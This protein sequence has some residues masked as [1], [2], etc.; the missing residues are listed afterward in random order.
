MN[1]KIFVFVVCGKREHIDTLHLSL[2]YLKKYSKHEIKI[3]TDSSRNEIEILHDQVID[4]KTPTQYSHHQASIY[5]KTGIHNFL[6]KDNLYCYLDTDVVAVSASC[7]D[8]FK[9]FT[10][11]I[12]FAVD[13]CKIRKFSSS[14]VHC[15]CQKNREIDRQK[16]LKFTKDIHGVTVTNPFLIEK[17]KELQFQFDLLKKSF[18]KKL[19]T[20]L[21]FFLSRKQFHLNEEFYFNKKNKTWHIKNGDVVM[22][23]VDVEK[24]QNATGLIYNKW[25][26]KWYNKQGE[27]IWH[28]EC[29]HLTEYIAETF[30]IEVNNKN[31][32][33]WNGGVFLFDNSSTLFLDAWH[34]KTMQIFTL[35][36][37]K[38]RDQGT[39]I[40]T[41]WEF[42]L[43]NHPTLSKKFNFIA[44]YNNNGVQVNTQTEHITDDGFVTSYQPAFVHVYHNWGNKSWPIWQWIESNL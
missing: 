4:I 25:N 41:A 10:T 18:F 31:W 27:D 19:Y 1:N 43:V 24:M 21:R 34:N 15:D 28:D 13:H 12:K 29:N 26:K 6:P 33:H 36:N 38:V 42:G 16:F 5:L 3:I 20:A 23:D 7:D 35:P 37:W 39:L 30:N 8:V 2:Q 44:D 17:G 40:A 11:P 22:Y 32:Q 14:A 9:E